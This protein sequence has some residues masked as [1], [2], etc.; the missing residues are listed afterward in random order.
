MQYA[1]ILAALDVEIDRLQRARDLLASSP[2]PGEKPSKQIDS[3]PKKKTR[4]AKPEA[5]ALPQPEH[6]LPQIQKV[7]SKE[8]AR[9]RQWRSSSNLA[10]ASTALS[11]HVP[12]TPVVVSAGEAQKA[13]VR[14]TEQ[15]RSTQPAP[16]INDRNAEKS[17]D[18]LIRAF[19]RGQIPTR[20][21]M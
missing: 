20:F 14:E 8:R 17:L 1:K 6:F 5:A 3:I 11:S 7:P 15:T 4:K 16:E 10:I 12:A 2:F 9:P 13:R 19:N 21:E 18:S